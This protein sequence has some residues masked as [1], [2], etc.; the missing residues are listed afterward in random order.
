MANVI[1]KELD[2]FETEYAVPRKTKIEN[3]KEI[4][5]EEPEPEEIDVVCLVDRF[6]YARTVDYAVYERNKEAAD[7]ENR[8]QIVCK[9]TDKIALFTNQG[10]MHLVKV[11]D[12]PYGKFRDKG[13]PVD[14][15]SNFDSTQ[16]ER[17]CL[18]PLF[19]KCVAKNLFLP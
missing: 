1:I 14:N 19:R 8:Y 17:F 2:A 6:G 9:S 4:V 18:P 15:V 12:L 10:Q 16:E 13:L 3:G 7:S 5:L 11:S